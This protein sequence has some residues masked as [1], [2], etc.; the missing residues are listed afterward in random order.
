MLINKPVN[1]E[2]SGSYLAYL[3]DDVGVDRCLG[4]GILNH[5]IEL[6]HGERILL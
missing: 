3:L 4:P 5:L 6:F 2:F 1:S